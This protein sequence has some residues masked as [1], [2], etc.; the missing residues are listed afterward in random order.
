M[1]CN[2]LLSNIFNKLQI[3]KI[4]TTVLIL[5][6]TC[7]ISPIFKKLI[8]KFCYFSGFSPYEFTYVLRFDNLYICAKTQ[9]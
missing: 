5:T 8:K 7:H 4:N 1:L 2:F 3:K 9:Y 6:T